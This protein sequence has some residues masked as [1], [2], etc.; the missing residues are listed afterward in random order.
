M[1]PAPALYTIRIEGNLG[2]T[3]LSAFPAMTARREGTHT[4]LT[5][6]L[7]QSALFGVL[8]VV[9]GLGLCLLEVRRGESPEP[10]D[11]CPG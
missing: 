7:D 1:S 5:G 3:L 8:A 4:L 11:D 9:E 6:L 10:G 2:P